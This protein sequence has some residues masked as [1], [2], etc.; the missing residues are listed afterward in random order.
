MTMKLHPASEAAVLNEESFHAPYLAENI[1]PGDFLKAEV[2][3]HGTSVFKPF[4]VWRISPLGIELVMNAQTGFD[5]TQRLDLLIKYGD[6]VVSHRGLVVSKTNQENG[7]SLCAIRWINEVDTSKRS[8][9]KRSSQRWLCGAEYLPTGVAT[10]PLRFNDF[11]HFRILELSKSGMRLKT[12]LRN[13]LIVPGMQLEGMIT[14]PLVG[15]ANVVFEAVSPRIAREDGKDYLELGCK[16]VGASKRLL[17]LIGQYLFQ[18]GPSVSPDELRKEQ[19]YVGT[20]NPAIT[21][22]N[23]RTEEEYRKVLELRRLAW[24]SAG[25]F[26]GEIAAE[27]FAD[28]YDA[29]ARILTASYKGEI[30]ASLRL[31]F[32]QEN[33]KLEHEQYIELPPGLPRMDELV[34]ITRVVVHPDFRGIDLLYLLFKQTALTCIQAGKRYILGNSE[35]SLLPMYR[36]L[37]FE[38][39]PVEFE[40]EKLGIRPSLFLG[41]VHKAV[42]GIGVN[43]LVWNFMYSE[44]V[45]FMSTNDLM[46]FGPSANIRMATFRLF[47]PLTSFLI[48]R[49]KGGKK[50]SKKRS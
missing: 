16:F 7:R 9:E 24:I 39:L 34:E 21:F 3:V 50:K 27:K 28:A 25:K 29:R 14:F 4:Q 41:D 19:L 47:K 23:V 26:T 38:V 1:R 37:G 13:K 49:M 45:Q 44:L 17:D 8:Q 33:E 18:F 11:I 32:P 46:R 15:Q 10:N 35:K 2:A 36:K 31:V 5:F 22:S 30:I 40:I 48:G 6:S 20:V 42:A 12:S 43:P